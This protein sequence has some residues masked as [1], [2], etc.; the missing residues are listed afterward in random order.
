[1]LSQSPAAPSRDPRV[2]P[3]PWSQEGRELLSVASP[4]LSLPTC[5]A[6]MRSPGPG[7]WV[8]RP[9]DGQRPRGERGETCRRL[10]AL[11]PTQAVFRRALLASRVRR[12]VG[13]Q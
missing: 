1:M 7:Q 3:S 12:G 5:R 13:V 4:G 2:R 6:G 8:E 11:G 10:Q 9:G